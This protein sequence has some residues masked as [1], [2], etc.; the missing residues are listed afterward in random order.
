MIMTMCLYA[1]S[2]NIY[3]YQFAEFIYINHKHGYEQCA[4]LSIT[5]I[6]INMYWFRTE[7]WDLK[8]CNCSVL[9]ELS[10]NSLSL[11]PHFQHQQWQQCSYWSITS[12]MKLTIVKWLLD[13][14]SFTFSSFHEPNS[15][16]QNSN[17][18]KIE[19]SIKARNI[20]KPNTS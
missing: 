11:Y 16:V 10:L 20:N 18:T 19:H 5:N 3:T 4:H 8:V 15:N 2:T 6:I 9:I 13:F 12:R 17:Q 7:L 14:G 1:S